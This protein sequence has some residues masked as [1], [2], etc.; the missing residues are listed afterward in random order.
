[1]TQIY[2]SLSG[3]SISRPQQIMKS[4]EEKLNELK[5]NFA[6]NAVKMDFMRKSDGYNYVL[7]YIGMNPE[8]AEWRI[9]KTLDAS[10]S[11]SQNS[12][13]L[14]SGLT[15]SEATSKFKEIIG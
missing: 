10:V 3:S 1:M 12:E 6:T 2:K 9:W 13:F 11:R 15:K 5:Q 4:T 7:G 14:H 8:D